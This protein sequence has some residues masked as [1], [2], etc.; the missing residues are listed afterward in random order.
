V[1]RVLVTGGS[2]FIGRPTLAALVAAGHE[3]HALTSRRD[4]PAVDG[5]AWVACDLGEPEAVEA[6]VAAIAPGSLLH[7]AWYVEHGLFW[8]APENVQWVERSLALL[9]AFAAH[10]GRRVVMLG[11]CAEYDWASGDERFDER[12]T[13]LR[14]STLYGAAKDGLRRVGQAYAEQLGIEF[15]WGRMFFL[16]GPREPPGRLV[17]AVIRALLAGEDAAVSSGR[18][19]R[20]LLY[21]D[22]VAQALAAL[23]ASDVCGAVNIASGEAIA[24]RDV[25]A[26]IGRL[27]GREDLIRFGALAD[28]A[29]EPERIVASAARLSQEVGFETAWTLRAGLE[30][31]VSWWRKAQPAPRA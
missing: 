16:Y 29:D 2:G 14:P 12:S 11:S 10:G 4:P 31:A 18:Q 26:E 7:L 28:R 27:V 23:L 30:S 22:D 3:V 21:V 24:L 19:I 13:P 8:T 9:R 17:P 5:V 1:T 20:D 6:A 15:A 25:V